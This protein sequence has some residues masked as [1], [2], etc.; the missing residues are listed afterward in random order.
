MF[1]AETI[2]GA[3]IKSLGVSPQVVQQSIGQIQNAMAEVQAFK[4]G[5]ATAVQHFEG[6]FAA[7]QAQLDRIEAAVAGRP[8]ASTEPLAITH[9]KDAA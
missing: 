1:N 6:R 5:F 3:L 7:Q 8:L 4:A 9:A 2:I